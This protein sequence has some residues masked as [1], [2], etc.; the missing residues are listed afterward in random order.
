VLLATWVSA[1]AVGIAIAVLPSRNLTSIILAAALVVAVCVAFRGRWGLASAAAALSLGVLL[2]WRELA[3]CEAMAGRGSDEAPVVVFGEVVRGPE[4]IDSSEARRESGP[5]DERESGGVKARLRLV[6]ETR[7]IAGAARRSIVWV[8]VAQGVPEI[9]PG[10][11][12]RFAARLFSPR[13]LA[14]PGLP[15]A[16]FAAR[17]QQVEY[18]ASLRA[19]TDIHRLPAAVSWA[20]LPRRAAFFL[21]RAM[22]RVVNEQLDSASAAFVRTMVLGER[23]GVSDKVEDGFRAA[24]A[25]H[26]LSVSG[27]HLAVVAALV[28]GGLRWLASLVPSWALQVNAKSI[29]AG[30]SVPAVVLYMLLTG[31][32]LATLR[33]A[34]M[35][36]VLL[37]AL[38]VNRPFSLS[39]SVALA[40]LLLLVRS[41]LAITDV[42]FQLS[43]ASVLAL[44]IFARGLADTGAKR[45]NGRIRR[46]WVWLCRSLSASFAA[47]LITAPF[48]AHHF[49]E[50][51]PAAPIGNL[52]LVPL[53]ELAV[54]PCGLVGALMG[55][56]HPWLG[57]VPLWMA[58]QGSRLALAVAEIFRRAGP[59][60]VVRFPSVLETTLLVASAACL[61]L[62]LQRRCRR[63]RWVAAALVCAV[64][65][66]GSLVI[67]DVARR[68]DPNLRVTFIDVGQGDASLVEG[69]DGFVALVDGGGHYDDSFDT[70]ARVVE[71]LLRTRGIGRLDLVVL[72]H[73]HPDHLNG[74]LRVLDRFP[75]RMLW[76]SGDTGQNPRYAELLQRA[77]AQGTAISV[78]TGF[79]TLAGLHVAPGGPWLG[80]AIGPPPGLSTNDASL[81]VRFDYAGRSLLFPGDIGVDGEAELVAR[82]GLGQVV[83][84]D[85]VKVPHHGSRRSSSD[86]FIDVVS[87]E[88]GIISTGM[89]NNFHLPSPVTLAR[90]R[91]RRIPL[92]RTDLNGAVT[93][94]VDPNGHYSTTCERGCR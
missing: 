31:E 84:G 93:V 25:T 26:A 36:L 86:E 10:D 38:L 85:F 53:V 34:F 49:G 79:T 72:S 40:A 11:Q 12:V 21:R 64:G 61:L 56:I 68:S 59:V 63:L 88:L 69:P 43:F 90:Y 76:T 28:F 3:V 29:A 73:P 33:S 37:G 15:N 46:G 89:Y 42:S 39:A 80:D 62:G 17:V 70:G 5:V 55:M 30:L 50:V 77:R 4:V 67:R 54:L 16:L 14:N 74:L 1:F 20:A 45:A 48:V 66:T 32:A 71:P 82:A 78:P 58:G 13:G 18:F 91:E 22:A 94:I 41:P 35:S 23:T 9:A 2:G 83:R 24:G 7:T 27:L 92:L 44:G 47:S 65:A 57:A 19:A 87:P 6:V 51:T 52:V 8:S 75:V 60:I 81:V